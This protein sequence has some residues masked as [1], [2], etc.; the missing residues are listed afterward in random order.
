MEEKKRDREALAVKER[1]EKKRRRDIERLEAE[2]AQSVS[3]RD[4]ISTRAELVA[5]AAIKTNTPS[6]E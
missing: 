5:T 6:L 1:E 3:A 2:L 4:R